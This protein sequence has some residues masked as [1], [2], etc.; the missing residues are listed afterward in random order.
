MATNL[1]SRMRNWRTALATAILLRTFFSLSPS[2]IHPDEHFQ[3]P[4]AIADIIF[5]WATK[6]SWEFVDENPARS[7]M[8]IWAIYGAPMSFI[9][10]LYGEIKPITMFYVLRLG[11]AVATWVLCDMAIDRLSTNKQEKVK[12]MVF[13]ATSYVTWT[14]QSHTFSNSIETILLFWC[15]VII[16][17][18]KK[19]ETDL[20]LRHFDMA[21]LGFMI[22]FGVFNRITF[23]AFLI[24]PGLA[25]IQHFKTNPMTFVSF[26][27]SGVATAAA[28]VSIDTWCYGA[29]GYVITPLN[30][31]IYNIDATNLA[32]HGLHSRFNHLLVNLP[33][34]LGPGMILLISKKYIKSLP[35]QA[36]VSGLVV[37]S[38]FPH[39]EPRFL[40]PVVPLLCCCFD[41]S[42]LS[43]NGLNWFFVVWY[44]Y[45]IILGVVMGTLHQGGVVPAQRFIGEN[46]IK[47]NSNTFIW[48]Q[49]YSP[50]IWLMGRPVDSVNVFDP[51]VTGSNDT[52]KYSPIFNH[53]DSQNYKDTSLTTVVDL[54]GC[55]PDWLKDSM[56]KVSRISALNSSTLRRAY[57]V[58][59]HAAVHSNNLI[60]KLVTKT[61]A[62]G[63]NYKLENVWDT[64]WHLS[65]EGLDISDK[66]TFTPGLGIWEIKSL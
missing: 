50:P 33:Y 24:L 1:F 55:N 29:G 13:V 61:K 36:A 7:Y 52:I 14:F 21:L 46:L 18:L 2:Y 8:P 27:I 41:V 17:E 66:R 60:S 64:K 35:M 5:G 62:N 58:A 49:T 40:I 32:E 44:L 30:N 54:M 4:E 56:T 6:K 23:P 48:W 65:I 11:F 12:N 31:L 59:P 63:V 28:G 22:A 34:L 19:A 16:H 47:N 10:A 9:Q 38:I 37:L 39:Q 26:V 43:S 53:L 57:L 20:F 15:L 42:W 51:L 25:L 45:N 3:G